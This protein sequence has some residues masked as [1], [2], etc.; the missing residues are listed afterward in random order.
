[1]RRV[2]INATAPTQEEIDREER[3]AFRVFEISDSPDP[4]GLFGDSIDV[5]SPVTPSQEP[6]KSDDDDFKMED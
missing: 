6:P 1:M 3:A 4:G 5:P 2:R